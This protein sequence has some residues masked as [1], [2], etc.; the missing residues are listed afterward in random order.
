MPQIVVRASGLE[1]RRGAIVMRE[2][3]APSDLE[4][5]QF[6]SHLLERIGWALADA[7]SIE[8]RQAELPGSHASRR[9][10]RPPAG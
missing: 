4:S 9:P 5:E 6:T 3:V 10:A 7:D 8:S 2:R 1:S